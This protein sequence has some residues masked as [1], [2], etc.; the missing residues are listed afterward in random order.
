MPNFSFLEN[1]KEFALFAPACMEAE[2]ICAAAPAMCAAACRKAME[3]AIKWVYS[4]D[5]SVHVP[6]KDNL[7]SLIHEPSFRN[8][9]NQGTWQKL[10]YIL[11]AGNLAVHTERQIKHSDAVLALRC[12][13]EFVLWIDYCYGGNYEERKF[14]ESSIPSADSEN[15]AQADTRKIKEQE[16]NLKQKE[17]EIEELRRQIRELSAKYTAEKEEHQNSRSFNS[18][19]ISEFATRKTFIDVDLKQIGW[20]FD[21]KKAHVAEEY[22]VTDMAGV[23]GQTGYCDYVLFGDDALPLAVVEAKRTSKDPKMGERQA[24]LYADC[25]E[26]KFKRRPFIFLTNGFE[27]F[28]WDGK[29]PPREVSGIFGKSDLERLMTRREQ[30]ENDPKS[31]L[32]F[33]INDKIT[34]RYYQ[35]EAIRAVCGGLEKGERKFLL[36]MATGTGKTRTASSLVDVLNRAGRLTNVLFLADRTALVKQAKDDFRTYLP[37]TTLCNLCTAKDDK[38]AKIIFSTYPTLLNAVDGVKSEDGQRLFGPA[39]FDLIIIDESHR[40]IFKKYKAI[41]DY[42]DAVLVGLTA[43]P[44]TDVDRNTYDFF[45]M[46][47][48]LPTYAYDYETAVYTDRYLVPYYNYEVK[49]KFLDDGIRYDELSEKDK[50]RFEE[51]FTEDGLTPDYVPSEAMN[52]FV[53]NEDT[54]KTVLQDLMEK[55]IRTAGGDRLGKTIIFAQNKRHADFIVQCFNKLYPQYGGTFARR[56]VC[57][58][59]YAQTLIDDF[60]QA[61]KEPHIAVS[62]D[63]LDTGIDVPEIVN[64]VFFKK[65]RS[66]TKFWQMIGRG[67]RLCTGLSCSD[68]INGDYI[69]KRRFLI[70][71]YCANF[72]FFRAHKEGFEARETKSLT[73]NIFCKQIRLIAAL[74]DS[75][76]SDDASQAWRKELAE[77][78]RGQVLSLNTELISV[79]LKRRHVLK[80]QK[81]ESF[82]CLNEENKNELTTIIA[83]LV[84]SNDQDEAAKFFDNFMYGLMLDSLEHSKNLKKAQ[85]QL[86]EIALSLEKKSTVPQVKAKLEFIKA[87][88]DD[89]FF[90]ECDVLML[91]KIRKELRELMRFLDN[92]DKQ[93]KLVVTKLHDPIL[94]MQEGNPLESAYDFED[95]R[96][97]VNRYVN[98]HQNT[99]AIYKLTRN[100]PL[101]KGDY[102]ELE[103]ILTCEL[104]SKADYAR[105][106]G[107]TPFGL[108]IRKIAKLDREAAMQA[109]STFINDS[110]L[111]QSQ[112]AFVHQIINYIVLNG[113][114]ENISTLVNSSPFNRSANFYRLFDGKTQEA[115]IGTIKQIKENAVQIKAS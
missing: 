27:T 23:Q 49:T 66:K 97:K 33:P 56:V 113:Y 83:P 42:F 55:G 4:A 110:S 50:E 15:S 82:V 80:Y 37:D 112:I 74:Q 39:H 65:V 19:D 89:N 20:S 75:A 58:D 3:L 114:M 78:C 52:R 103:R 60:K 44:K 11:K 90:A 101:N 108:L 95:Y 1:K 61:E 28:F 92:D 24:E 64:L 84:W 29:L 71:D 21:G 16:E 105:E 48:G 85:K 107:D 70:F 25:L 99:L 86:K 8:L 26:R 81:E 51:D 77:T 35:K 73:E 115:I 31:L 91:E 72:E 68:Q 100:I 5:T 38:N 10:L 54:V 2:K 69:G 17:A 6:Y 32:D 43:T 46:E 9:M 36:V 47:H 30:L 76:F 111:N 109:F 67:T 98:E 94:D 62:V 18:E 34:D 57:D 93:N 96:A 59:T 12:L 22:E 7:A 63:M 14:E 40:S 106:Y 13:F 87:I 41:F 102:L 53:F 45:E 79:K 88:N 104:G